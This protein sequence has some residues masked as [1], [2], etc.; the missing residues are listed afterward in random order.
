MRPSAPGSPEKCP[1]RG[2]TDRPVS[3]YNGGGSVGEAT[4]GIRNHS[5]DCC[6]TV[7]ETQPA[8]QQAASTTRRRLTQLLCPVKLKLGR[9]RPACAKVPAGSPAG[10]FFAFGRKEVRTMESARLVVRD[11]RE[12]FPLHFHRAAQ[13]KSVAFV[14][15]KATP[16][17]ACDTL[18]SWPN[19]VAHLPVGSGII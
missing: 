10:T 13:K 14:L 3:V 16:R 2:L 19:R 5:Q 9:R 15:S 8:G 18:F 1:Y 6:R 17:N 4:T 7:V 12:I 11:T